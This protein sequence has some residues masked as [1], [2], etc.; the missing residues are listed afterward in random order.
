M[1]SAQNLGT[2]PGMADRESLESRWQTNEAELNR[3]NAMSPLGRE[4]HVGRIEGLEAQQDAIEF[5][6]GR[7]DAPSGSRKWSGMR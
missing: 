4:S 7:A 2:I 3:L 5:E 1:R 6:L